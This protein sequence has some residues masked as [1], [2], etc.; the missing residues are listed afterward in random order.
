MRK[1]NWKKLSL[2]LLSGSI[3]F[4]VPA[5]TQT[6]IGISTLASLVT[7][8]GVVYLIRKVID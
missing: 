6:A 5:C 3:L 2:A 7:A 8:G 1:M 4:Q